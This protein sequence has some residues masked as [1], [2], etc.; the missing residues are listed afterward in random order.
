M[1]VDYRYE[2]GMVGHWKGYQVYILKKKE[3]I[4]NQHNL[5]DD[6]VYVIADDGMRM[7]NRG[8]VIGYLSKNGSVN[9]CDK[10]RYCPVPQVETVI[11]VSGEEVELTTNIPE[12]YFDS[13]AG[14]V[15][16]FFK[17]LNDPII[18]E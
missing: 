3:Y 8:Y 2:R 11:S 16:E 9:E 6:V 18:V 4:D 12:G 14:E 1:A 13:F 10:V 7:V 5:K 15:T 17:H